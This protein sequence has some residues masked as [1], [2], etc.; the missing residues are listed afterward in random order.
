ML[1][2]LKN[3]RQIAVA[4]ALVVSTALSTAAFAEDTDKAQVGKLK[5]EV[6]GGVG[7]IL[8]SKKKMACT[9]DKKDGGVENYVGRV[10]KIGVDL[11]VTKES[12]ILWAVYAPTDQNDKGALAGKYSGVAAEATVGG[13]V[14]ANALFSVGNNFTLQP[15][16][17]QG[18]EGLNIAGGLSQ[19]KLEFVE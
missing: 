7:L 12:T 18:Q 14:G 13:G 1:H 19:I 15:F 4:T 6:E 17:V 2:S 10:T 16:S 9:F 5:C 3:S 11:G 8:G